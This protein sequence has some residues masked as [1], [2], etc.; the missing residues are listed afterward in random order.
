MKRGSNH[1]KFTVTDLENEVDMFYNGINKFEFK[2]GETVLATAY[3][4]DIMRKASVVCIDYQT[5]H[6]METN[7]WMD[8]NKVTKKGYGLN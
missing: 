2:E 1:I 6:A 8:K 3:C 4:P 7:D 5:K